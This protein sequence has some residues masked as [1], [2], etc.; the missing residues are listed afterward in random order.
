MTEENNKLK[1]EIN[2]LRVDRGSSELISSYKKQI[3]D[4]NGRIH[5]LEQEKSNLSA[6]VLNLENE[7]KVRLSVQS[8]NSSV[9]IKKSA[10]TDIRGSEYS[11]SQSEFRGSAMTSPVQK[12][13]LSTTGGGT[14]SP[15]EDGFGIKMVDSK[16]EPSGT[17]AK[18]PTYGLSESQHSSGSGT[19]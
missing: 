2:G 11:Q 6:Q 8:Y 14:V 9:D 7:L 10:V 5:E 13:G 1:S 4:L 12:Y 3:Q 18:S 15:K 17:G 19:R 16:I